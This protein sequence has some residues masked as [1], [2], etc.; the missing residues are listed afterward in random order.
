MRECILLFHFEPERLA[1]MR[2]ALLP[3][4]FR[5]KTVD[6]AQYAQPL[7]ALVGAQD[8]PPTD[9]IYDGEELPGEMLV[10]AG[11]TDGR[12]DQLLMAF[13][14]NG[15]GRIDCK[16]VLTATNQHWTPPALYAELRREHEAMRQGT[17]IHERQ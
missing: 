17:P 1:K 11:L 10:M 14:K 12:M 2:R 4:R 5:I 15:V 6:L 13:R 16:A 8:V 7:G 3:L 9:A